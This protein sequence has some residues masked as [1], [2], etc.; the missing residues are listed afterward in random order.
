MEKKYFLKTLLK[1]GAHLGIL[2]V[3]PQMFPY[4]YGY[5]GKNPLLHAH[6][7][8]FLMQKALVFLNGVHKTNHQI[9]LVN[10]D[11]EYV[12]LV[13]FLGLKIKQPYVN[14]AWIG[15]LL[16]N[17]GQMKPSITFFNQFDACF[18]P[19]LNKHNNNFPKYL[20]S[21]KKLDGIKKIRTLPAALF[22]FQTIKNEDILREAKILKIPT[23]GFVETSTKTSDIDYPIPLNTKSFKSTY[24]FCQLWW[25][26]IKK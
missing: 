11:P 3:A 16:T 1:S 25:F 8:L 9:L 12:N 13:Q 22:L 14:E 19:T 4:I 6:K 20:N 15:G 17:W 21:R 5:R 10:S 26:I 2:P 24:L 7:I 23:V 18:S